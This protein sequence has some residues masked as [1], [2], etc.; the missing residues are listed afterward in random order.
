[1]SK[2]TQADNEELVAAQNMMLNA[3]FA[4]ENGAIQ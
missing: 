4:P 1:M 2:Y 3:I